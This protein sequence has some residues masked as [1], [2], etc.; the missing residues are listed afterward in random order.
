MHDPMQEL[1]I[2]T[3]AD[4]LWNIAGPVLSN[5]VSLNRQQS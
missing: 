3:V 5:L 1:S 2:A 4:T